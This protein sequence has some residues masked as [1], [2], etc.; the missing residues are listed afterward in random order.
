MECKYTQA[1]FRLS[2]LHIRVPSFSLIL[3]HITQGDLIVF[4]L[5]LSVPPVRVGLLSKCYIDLSPVSCVL[6]IRRISRAVILFIL[7]IFGDQHKL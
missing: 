6:H 5:V 4:V 2:V 3:N 1:T 7:T